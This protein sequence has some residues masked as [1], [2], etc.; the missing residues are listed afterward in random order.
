M[1]I[2]APLLHFRARIV[3]APGGRDLTPVA[4]CIVRPNSTIGGPRGQY[5]SCGHCVH[6]IDQSQVPA[7]MPSWQLEDRAAGGGEDRVPLRGTVPLGGLHRHDPGNGQPG[8]TAPI[9]IRPSMDGAMGQCRS[10]IRAN[11]S[12]NRSPLSASVTKGILSGLGRKLGDVFHDAPTPQ[13]CGPLEQRVSSA[14]NYSSPCL[15]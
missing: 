15:R 10:R 6:P 1:T 5:V 7:W 14:R 12:S 2:P 8:S 13:A 11:G 9:A 4:I 3:V